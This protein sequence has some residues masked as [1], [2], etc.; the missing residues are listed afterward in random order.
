MKDTIFIILHRDGTIVPMVNEPLKEHFPE[1]TRFFET[2]RETTIGDLSG[3][4]GSKWTAK[5]FKEIAGK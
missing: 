1:G 4:Y 2:N 3:W 5:R